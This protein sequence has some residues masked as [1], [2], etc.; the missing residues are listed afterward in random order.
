MRRCLSFT[1]DLLITLGIGVGVFFVGTRVPALATYPTLDALG[2]LIIWSFLNRT[3]IQ[4]VFRAT[5]GKAL[6]GLVLIRR[7]DG[8]RPTFWLLVKAWFAGSVAGVAAIGELV[9][10]SG[11]GVDYK[12]ESFPVAVRA[13]DVRALRRGR[14]PGRAGE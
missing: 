11:S 2:A 10:P 3:I 7:T 5:I 1:V 6:F 9:G 12:A 4:W 14:A 8:E 13:R